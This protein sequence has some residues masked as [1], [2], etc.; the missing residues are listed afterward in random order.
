MI[1]NSTLETCLVYEFKKIQY[2]GLNNQELQLAFG[3]QP[4][5]PLISEAFLHTEG[6]TFCSV[7][8]LQ[9]RSGQSVIEFR[10]IQVQDGGDYICEAN[11][12]AVDS[13]GDTIVKNL[14]IPVN[15]KCKGTN[16][17]FLTYL[18]VPILWDSSTL[19]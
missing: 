1:Y 4:L 8:F 19:A 16:P 14:K 13:Q 10:N 18:H 3:I 5:P 7:S 15:I 9:Q 12:S 11:N 2:G 17:F 6:Q